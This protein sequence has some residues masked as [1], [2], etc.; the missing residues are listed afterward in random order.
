MKRQPIDWEKLFNF[1]NIQTVHTTQQQKI[2]NN[3]IEKWSEDLN[4]Q[5]SKGDIQMGNRHMKRCATLLIIREMQI[6][7]TMRYC[8][9]PVRMTIIKKSASNK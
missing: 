4:R 1:Q 6:K 5:F 8:L 3:P 2:P 9:K 7:I